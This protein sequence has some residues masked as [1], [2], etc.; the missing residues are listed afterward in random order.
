MKSPSP[1][2]QHNTSKSDSTVSLAKKRQIKAAAA[3]NLTV[4]KAGGKKTESLPLK[5]NQTAR[6]M[7]NRV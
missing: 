6:E 3:V 1:V 5:A 4:I 2:Q 7:M